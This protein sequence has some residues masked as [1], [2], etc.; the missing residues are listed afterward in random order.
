MKEYVVSLIPIVFLPRAAN[1]PVSRSSVELNFAQ[2]L[3]WPGRCTFNRRHRHK[4]NH[5]PLCRSA[6]H[7]ISRPRSER[8]T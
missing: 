2:Q 1:S 8:L 4:G 7:Q 5:A 6:S 3:L